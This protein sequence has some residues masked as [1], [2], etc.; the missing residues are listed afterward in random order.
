MKKARDLFLDYLEVEIEEMIERLKPEIKQKAVFTS[1][2][3][4]DRE[5][6][7]KC[8]HGFNPPTI[9]FQLNAIEE[10]LRPAIIKSLETLLNHEIIHAFGEKK[11]KEAYQ[12]QDKVDFKQ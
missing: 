8:Y 5:A 6:G 12:K 10:T 2:K 3:D 1:V 11:E 9:E 7:A 4:G